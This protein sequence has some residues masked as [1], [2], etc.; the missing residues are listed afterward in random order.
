M[1]LSISCAAT[2]PQ[3]PPRTD[4]PILWEQSGTYSTLGRAVRLLIRDRAG[5]AQVPLTDIPV[6]F[7]TQM[8]LVAGLGPTLSN[9]MGIRITRVWEEG[10]RLRVQERQVHP[11]AQ[12]TPGVTRA[13]PWTVVII[14]RSDLNVE[15]FT[16]RIPP[17]V[18][19]GGG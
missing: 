17:N 8:V 13:S 6:D 1:L 16:T 18:I 15:G 4:V 5:L 10:G 7:E 2:P 11:G 9:E 12:K 14:P 19:A 3:P